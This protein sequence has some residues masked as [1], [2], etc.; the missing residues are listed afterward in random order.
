MNILSCINRFLK[1]LDMV[2]YLALLQVG[3]AGAGVVGACAVIYLIIA[4]IDLKYKMD[5][6]CVLPWYSLEL[7]ANSPCCLLSRFADI[8]QVKHDLLTG[9]KSPACGKCW[10]LESQGNKS[11][12]QFEN[13]FLDYKH[14]TVI[15][16]NNH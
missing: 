14:N 3:C 5:T 15:L 8:K 2:Y 11:R 6:F 1:V 12:R 10:D 4:S 16:S 7:P 9:V 13:E